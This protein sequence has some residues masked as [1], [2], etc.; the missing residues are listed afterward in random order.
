MTTPC[1]SCAHDRCSEQYGPT[2]VRVVGFDF[3]VIMPTVRYNARQ[4]TC[5]PSIRRYFVLHTETL[6][7]VRKIDLQR[8]TPETRASRYTPRC[9]SA[10]HPCHLR[11]FLRPSSL[12]F[13]SSLFFTPL[14][15]FPC[16]RIFLSS[17]TNEIDE[18][19]KRASSFRSIRNTH[20]GSR[21]L[22]RNLDSPST[23]F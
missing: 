16:P 20:D 6:F 14:H 4:R 18:I 22:V 10:A 12:R 13:L 19:A 3:G 11:N 15:R 5:Q 9:I 17:G 21:A 2:C 8:Y 1:V 7:A 23:V